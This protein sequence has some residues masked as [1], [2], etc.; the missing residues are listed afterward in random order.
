MGL[1]TSSCAIAAILAVV[2]TGGLQGQASQVRYPQMAPLSEYLMADRSAEIALARTAA[3]PAIS[4][5]A[6]I[7]VLGP[8]GY[9]TAVQGTNGFVC[10]VERS[11]MAPFEHPAFWNPKIR[12]PICYNPPAAQTILPITRRRTTLALA[13]IPRAAMLDSMRAGARHTPA[14]GAMAYMLSKHGFLDD[15]A[16][17]WRPHLMIFAPAA[18]SAHWGADVAGSPVMS[19]PQYVAEGDPI[20]LFLIPVA[21]WSD[22]SQAPPH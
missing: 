6:S 21:N 22:G 3:P 4:D 9:E 13:G 1:T 2:L 11:W 14:P 18:D 12:G 16:G 7:L 10:V 20:A 19:L 15:S 8:R 5:H 17:A